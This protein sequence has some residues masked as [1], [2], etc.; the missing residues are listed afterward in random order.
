ML[1]KSRL[2][3]GGASG[4]ANLRLLVKRQLYSYLRTVQATDRVVGGEGQWFGSFC[5]FSIL[6]PF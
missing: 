2:E 6:S 3:Q 4:G 5:L 1:A